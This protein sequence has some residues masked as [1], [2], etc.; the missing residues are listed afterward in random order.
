[1]FKQLD[2]SQDGILSRD[3]IEGG[4]DILV[5]KIG[6][7]DYEDLLL[8]MDRNGDGQVDYHEFITAAVDKITLLNEN[9]LVQAFRVIDADSSGMIT[10]DELKSAFENSAE[11]KDEQLWV[12]IMKEVDTDND[13]QIS[14][15]EFKGSLG[16]FFKKSLN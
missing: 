11:K 8:S 7:L 16:N 5:G 15:E 14:L 3:E 6:N 10:M 12:D 2:T 1:M 13:G 4:L 9:S